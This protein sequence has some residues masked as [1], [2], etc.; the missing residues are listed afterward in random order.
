MKSRERKVK[1]WNVVPDV[2]RLT[3]SNKASLSLILSD[4]NPPHW[5]QCRTAPSPLA[6]PNLDGIALSQPHTPPCHFA[7]RSLLQNV[8]L[9]R[10]KNRNFAPNFRELKK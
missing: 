4:S 10:N 6:S 2:V 9:I 7:A 8:T 5:A 3:E 1:S